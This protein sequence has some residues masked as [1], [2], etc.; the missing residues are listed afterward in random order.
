[1]GSTFA[2]RIE[3]VKKTNFEWK[4]LKIADCFLDGHDHHTKNLVAFKIK[5]L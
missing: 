1:M 4:L 5:F 2:N 3:Q